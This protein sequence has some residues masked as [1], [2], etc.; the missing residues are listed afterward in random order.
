MH[1]VEVD[2]VSAEVFEGGVEGGFDIVGVV[3]YVDGSE[4]GFEN[5]S[6]IDNVDNERIIDIPLFHSFVVMKI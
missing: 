6:P 3:G 2:V 4:T 5:T 1:E